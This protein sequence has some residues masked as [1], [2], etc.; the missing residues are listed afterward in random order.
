[1]K[2]PKRHNDGQ[3]FKNDVGRLFEDEDDRDDAEDTGS[4]EEED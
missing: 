3:D 2:D 4:D 1:M